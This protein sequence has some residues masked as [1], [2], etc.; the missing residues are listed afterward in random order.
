[1]YLS[2]DVSVEKDFALPQ[3]FVLGL[4]LNVFNLLNSQRPISFVKADTE[5]FGDVWGRQLPRWLQLQVAL[6]F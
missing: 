1:M 3:G 2:N 6:K 4:R 5:L